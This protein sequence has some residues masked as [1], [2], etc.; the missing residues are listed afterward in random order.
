MP[1]QYDDVPGSWGHQAKHWPTYI[2]RDAEHAQRVFVACSK[3]NVVPYGSYVLDGLGLRVESP[4]MYDKLELHM[5]RTGYKTAQE[6][7]DL[8]EAGE[9]PLHCYNNFFNGQFRMENYL[10]PAACARLTDRRLAGETA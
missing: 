2:C 9:L 3:E 10:R 7:I 5:R 8:Y 4:A 1:L 6:V